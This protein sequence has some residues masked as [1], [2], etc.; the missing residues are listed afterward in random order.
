MKI[1][2]LQ[3]NHLNNPV[4]FVFN[5]YNFSWEITENLSKR[6]KYTKIIVSTDYEFKNIV[7]D[8]GKMLHYTHT[9]KILSLNLSGFTRYY[10][11]VEVRNNENELAMSSVAYFE[12]GK[13]NYEWKANWITTEEQTEAMPEFYKRFN[14][15]KEVNKATV[16]CCG[17][18][19][20]EGYINHDK[21]GDEFLMPGYYSYDLIQQYQTYDV[22]DLIKPGSNLIS[23]NLGNGWYRGRF[24]FDGGYE[25]IYGSSLM[26]IAELHIQYSDGTEEIIGTDQSWA[27]KQ[28][29][30]Y[31]NGIYDGEVINMDATPIELHT[32]IISRSRKLNCRSNIPVVKERSYQV[33]QIIKSPKGED[34]LD[35]GEMIT[36]WVELKL[37][38]SEHYHIKLQYGEILVDGNFYNDNLR[39]AKAEFA[40]SGKG[41]KDWIRPH[42]TYYGFRY[43]KISGIKN[44]TKDMFCAYRIMSDMKQNGNIQTS[45]V[46]VKQLIDNALRSQKCNFLDIPTDC[47][48]RDE[49]MGWTGD[50]AV[51]A[52][53]ACFQM[54]A[55]AFLL[56]YMRNLHRE[57]KLLDGAVPFFVPTP[58]IKAHEHIN[59]FL[60]TS[61]ACTWGDAATIVPWELYLHTGDK[62]LLQ[63]MYPTM[64]SWLSYVEKRVKSNKIPYLWQNDDQLGDWLALDNGDNNNP[65]G[66]TDPGLI[67]SVYFYHSTELCKKVA[68]V[69]GY[70][71]DKVYYKDLMKN[72]KKAFIKFYLTEDGELKTE[73][74]QTAYAL[75]IYNRLFQKKQMNCLKQGILHA[76][77]EYGGHLSTGFVGTSILCDALSEIGLN[78]KAYDLLLNTEYPGWLNEVCMDATTIWERWNSLNKDGTVNNNGMNSFNH[79]AYGAIVGWIYEYV[80]GFTWDK[81]NQ[82]MLRPMP[83][84][85]LR[86]VKGTY[87]SSI[88]EITIFWK[89][90]KSGKVRYEISVPFQKKLKVLLPNQTVHYL[91]SGTHVLEA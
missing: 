25:N 9:H 40:Y 36:G 63:E 28:S 69:L 7:Y 80:C 13:E 82:I 3:L 26:L 46:L 12:L 50:I 64:K 74:T 34:I 19:L 88:G 75:I 77:N 59:P 38:E 66:R 23:F 22:T 11:K 90:M 72:I 85:R 18:G 70:E 27:V 21:I 16:Y 65:I 14:I 62:L 55:S 35:F 81:Y 10:W 5:D 15:V 68:D 84:P 87:H 71:H 56:N 45:N 30:I 33:R 20:Y 44:I 67:A 24:V 57:Q 4:G 8:S 61:G 89:Y 52:R 49:R 37:D 29:S 51:F 17:Y 60:V 78:D 53:T 91:Q 31:Q 54:D 39:T 1:T 2:N 48:Q 86:S 58:K 32:R 73:K 47:P 83:N 6:N 79:Y 41:Q 42:F 43:V 76:L